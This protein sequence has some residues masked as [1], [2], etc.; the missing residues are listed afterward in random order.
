MLLAPD[1]LWVWLIAGAIGHSGGFV[2]IF[3]AL[4]AVA[5]DD[6]E[7][8][9]MSALIQGGGYAVGAL[10]GPAMGLIH[11]ITGRWTGGLVLLLALA[12]VY[13]VALSTA[14]AAAGR[15]RR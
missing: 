1:L 11:E 14:V 6:R 3:S 9:G 15:A 7:A 5:R 2:V 10:G 4:V 12:I 8:A 13:C